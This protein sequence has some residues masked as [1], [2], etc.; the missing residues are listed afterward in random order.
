MLKLAC[1]TRARELPDTRPGDSGLR[2]LCR[3]VNS[4]RYLS[5]TLSCDPMEMRLMWFLLLPLLTAQERGETGL[6]YITNYTHEQYGAHPQNWAAAQDGRGV[7]YFANN[8]AI[9]EYDGARWR[10]INV[11]NSSNVRSMA[12]GS[13]G[14]IYVGCQ[15]D[16][17]YLSG[18]GR[19]VSLIDR[20]PL[21]ERDFKDVWQVLPTPE[22]I[23]FR[24]DER[25]LRWSQSRGLRSWKAAKRFHRAYNLGDQLVVNDQGVGLKRVVGDRLEITSFGEQFADVVVRFAEAQDD[26]RW[27]IGARDGFMLWDGHSLR[28]LPT[29]ANLIVRQRKLYQAARLAGGDLALAFENGGLAIIGPD[30]RLRSFL[31]ESVGLA[32]DRINFILPDH[33]GGLWLALN[34]GLARVETPSP[35]SV[36]DQRL[37]LKG[38]VAAIARHRGVLYVATAFGLTRWHGRAFA[39]VQG[40]V[41]P[42]WSLLPTEA[43]LLAA[44]TDGLY[45][46]ESERSALVAKGRAIY[47]LRRS[48]RDSS[49]VY[50]GGLEGLATVRLNGGRWT[51]GERIAGVSMI[52][53]EIAEDVDG[54]LWLGTNYEGVARVR[55]PLVERFDSRHGLPPNWNKPFQAWGG[56]LFAT[57]G[58]LFRFAG[59]EF[60]LDSSVGMGTRGVHR[61]AEDAHGALWINATDDTG[62][63]RPG[64]AWDPVPLRR[65]GGVV[66]HTLYPEPSGI[67]WIGTERGVIR[68]DVSQRKDY[69]AAPAVLVR[70]P[71]SPGAK[72]H[73]SREPLRFDFSAPLADDDSRTTFQCYLDDFE[74]PPSAWT[75]ES[76]K[77]Y[78]NLSEGRYRFRVRARNLYGATST[79]AEAA[80]TV[81]PPWYRS[82]LAWIF[83]SLWASVFVWLLIKWRLWRLEARNRELEAAVAVRTREK[84]EFLGIAAHDLK[85]P[86]SEVRTAA[87]LLTEDIGKISPAEAAEYSQAIENQASHML[88]IVSNL[89][90]INRIEQGL[91]TVRKKECD[92]AEIA[93]KVV[94]AYRRRAELKQVVLH[95]AAEPLVLSGDAMLLEQVLDNLVSNA[96]KYSLCGREVFVRV[97]RG[98]ASA[99]LEVQDQGPGLTAEDQRKLFGKFARLSARPT[100]NESSTGLGLAIA[101]RLVEAMGGRIW[102]ESPP[103]QG[104]TF[105]VE[106][107]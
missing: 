35:L 60:A 23:Y 85:N 30:G 93:A 16:F 94:K 61:I 13:D 39:A 72:L 95:F 31:D 46:V 50:S 15:A 19:Y 3:I 69:T 59:H 4:F 24:A 12:L 80:F 83:Y 73:Y 48:S 5:L 99:R 36:F 42:C 106:L 63:A 44:C 92:L 21:S 54:T 68:F 98:P 28:D 57:A 107:T 9:L 101:K 56:I 78:T 27:L 79:Y 37:G 90:D 91:F 100:G 64:G 2:E 49:I 76:H 65:L 67:L 22:G 62:V 66:I 6:P 104:A 33:Q 88:D 52:V 84:D 45:S 81:L 32:D 7:M 10:A 102:C 43:G 105:F 53:R 25:L 75:R 11:P 103:G 82:W 38:A 18:D 17:G 29:E 20:T 86:L 47:A 40:I 41:S 77:D 51:P 14:L 87:H 70:P 97:S 55:P 8:D 1:P 96:I 34:N 58:G 74:R 26:G 89:L 71:F